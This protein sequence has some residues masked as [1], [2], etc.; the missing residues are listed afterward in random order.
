MAGNGD[1]KGLKGVKIFIATHLMMVSIAVFVVSLLLGYLLLYGPELKRVNQAN[2]ANSLEEERAAKARYLEGLARLSSAYG[3]LDAE[4]VESLNRMIPE[5]GDVPVLL[6]MIEAA[7]VNSD[8]N[9]NSI[10]FALGEPDGFAVGIADIATMN[11]NMSV[12]NASYTRFK[13]FLEALET[14]LRLFDIRSM[15]IDPASASY[16]LS[17]RAYVR[18]K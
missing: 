11:V 17:I 8:V 3:E 1:K 16:N 9:V 18:T 6:A 13:L 4:Q 14:N 2:V 5:D 10:S 12:S 7:A 15:D